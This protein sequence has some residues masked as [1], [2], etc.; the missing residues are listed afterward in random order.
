MFEI[1][2]SLQNGLRVRKR[3]TSENLAYLHRNYQTHEFNAGML[4]LLDSSVELG[5]RSYDTLLL[6]YANDCFE[7]GLRLALKAKCLAAR[8]SRL[9]VIIRNALSSSKPVVLA[10]ELGYLTSLSNS[11]EDAVRFLAKIGVERSLLD[12]SID[13]LGLSAELLTYRILDLSPMSQLFGLAPTN[14]RAAGQIHFKTGSHWRQASPDLKDVSEL[15]VASIS[16]ATS[17]GESSLIVRG[18]SATLPFL[19][20]KNAPENVIRR[21]SLFIAVGQEYILSRVPPASS[22]LVPKASVSL[23]SADSGHFGHFVIE[24]LPRLR[25]IEARRDDHSGTTAVIDAASERYASIIRSWST[26]INLKTVVSCEATTHENLLI[27]RATCF[28]ASDLTFGSDFSMDESKPTRFELPWELQTSGRQPK[29]SKVSG[30]LA[31][32]RADSG[33]APYRKLLNHR[34]L[35]ETLAKFMFESVEK[36]DLAYEKLEERLQNSRFIVTEATASI[37]ANLFLTDLVGKSV[38]LLLH[39]S[40][41]DQEQRMAGRFAALGARV[42]IVTGKSVGLQRQSDYMVG[43]RSF[44]TGLDQMIRW[45]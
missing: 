3:L 20:F 31:L 8:G 41:K 18:D 29:K 34:E 32:L 14:M 21:D 45:S 30:R 1:P 40:H 12:R 44:R 42:F 33:E 2:N 23:T 38:L 39:P 19:H 24:N 28:A 35:K 6:R 37:A 13:L 26:E 22:S 7:G 9:G 16:G 25:A 5:Q 11:S 10:E 27:A 17:F 36:G 15:S 4:R 43:V